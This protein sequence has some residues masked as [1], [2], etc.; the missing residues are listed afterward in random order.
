MMGLSPAAPW[1][2]AV[3]QIEWQI[4]AR[5]QLSAPLCLIAD[6]SHRATDFRKV[7]KPDM[8][9][10]V[11]WKIESPPRDRAREGRDPSEELNLEAR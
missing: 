9:R 1:P 10:L 4:C 6:V 8:V 2:A 3:I 5:P 7:P 11:N